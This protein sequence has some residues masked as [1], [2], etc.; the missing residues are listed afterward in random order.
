MDLR[1]EL[2]KRV[3]EDASAISE[4]ANGGTN[5]PLDQYIDKVSLTS[6]CD[7]LG[8]APE[9]WQSQDLERILVIRDGLYKLRNHLRDTNPDSEH[10]VERILGAFD[11]LYA[12][13]ERAFRELNQEELRRAQTEVAALQ[14]GPH[15]STA[16]IAGTA[17]QMKREA[18]EVLIQTHTTIKHIEFNL[19]KIDRS[20][21]NFEVLRN[22][23]LSV[24]RLSASVFA[25]KLSLE[26]NVIYQGVF[27][28]LTDGADRIVGELKNLVQQI[29][30]DYQTAGEFIA[31]LS[32]LTEK[33]T[34]FARLIAEFLNKA[35]LKS[36]AKEET[37]VTLKVQNSQQGEAVLAGVRDPRGNILL[38]GKNGNA[39]TVE[40]SSGRF[41][42]RYR[43]NDGPVY[44]LAIVPKNFEVM[45]QE[46]QIAVG[47]DDGVIVG[48]DISSKRERVV[49]IAIAPWGAKGARN[50]IVTGSRDGFVRRWTLAGR[51][52]QLSDQHY[53]Q[54]GKRVV[55]LMEHYGQIVASTGVELVFLDQDVRT[56]KTVKMPFQVV[57][58]D[59]IDQNTLVLCGDGN[60]VH[61]NLD[62]GTFSR[63][64]TASNNAE[65]TTVAAIDTERFYFGTNSGR[66]GVMELASGEELGSVSVN[67]P[68]RGIIPANKKIVAYGGEWKTKSKSA[69]VL[70]MDAVTRPI[71][72][73]E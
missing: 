68:V 59:T 71:V 24:Q 37:V 3:H 9:N 65:Y 15:V 43:L 60:I 53:E 7:S 66:I 26:Q 8:L 63:I 38:S 12:D 50:A 39:W 49:A 48:D 10:S 45:I 21:V 42:P 2:L 54:V 28:L 35:F 20:N 41:T 64:I 4:L 46:E 17:E 1:E 29:K 62:S 56:T 36:D 44:C 11:R 67:F 51:L 13:L 40:T 58:M 16:V 61:L 25:I 14:R 52:S 30:S 70:T 34:R 33:S 57:S 69:A 73:R 22:V 32:K 23:K 27:K 6:L 47:T 72:P 19:L 5:I 55:C 31:E 18:S